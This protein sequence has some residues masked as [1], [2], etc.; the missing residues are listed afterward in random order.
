MGED[1]GFGERCVSF[2]F[3]LIL[4]V[5]FIFVTKILCLFIS[6][7]EQGGCWGKKKI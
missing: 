2:W 7:C 1:F 4:C 6:V 3:G 5:L